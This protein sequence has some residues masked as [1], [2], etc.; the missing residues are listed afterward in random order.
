MNKLKEDRLKI[1]KDVETGKKNLDSHFPNVMLL[2][3]DIKRE[4][5]SPWMDDIWFQLRVNVFLEALNLHRA[6]IKINANIFQQNLHC[7]MDILSGKGQNGAPADF[8]RSAWATFFFVVPVVSTTFAS[9]D[10]LFSNIEEETLG[11]LLIDEAGQATPQ[12]A[13]GALWRAKR[14]VVVGDPLQ[15]EPI[16]TIPM[17][18]QE[19]LR[20]HFSVAETWLPKFCSV[21]LLCDRINKFGTNLKNASG[22]NFWVGAPLRVHRRCDNPMFDISNTIAYDGMMVFGTSQR[23]RLLLKNSC[24]I[25]IESQANSGHWIAAEGRAVEQL[26]ARLLLEGI[27]IEDIAIISPFSIVVRHLKYY[28]YY[29]ER[30]P[31]IGTIHTMQG[32]EATV[33]ILVLG[34]DPTKPGARVWASEKPNLLNVAVSRAKRRLYVIGNS[35]LWGVHPYFDRLVYLLNGFE[36]L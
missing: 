18:A 25:H 30:K 9:F 12:A 1:Q 20:K 36:E 26:V 2:E 24:W 5:S 3:D 6:F 31:K 11:W 14:A 35:K 15:L 7:M 33:I 16:L 23:Q 21:Q 4:L 13:V 29:E 32:K 10:R 34:G 19:A 22:K 17:T 28:F 27:K 8:V